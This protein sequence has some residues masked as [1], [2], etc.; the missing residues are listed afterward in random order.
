A[1]VVD[2]QRSAGS[3]GVFVLEQLGLGTVV[4]LVLGGGAIRLLSV[5]HRRNWSDGRYEQLLTFL[6]PIVALAVA[7]VVHGNAFIAAF[8]AGVAFGAGGA[9]PTGQH[10]EGRALHFAEFAEDAAQL[11]AVIAFFLFGNVFVE[12][13]IGQVD[14]RA[15]A[16]A[17]LSLTLVRMGP[18]WVSLLGSPLRTPSRLFVGWFGP[19]GLASIVFG[20]LLLEEADELGPLADELFAV[21]ALT[22]L[23]SVYLHGVTAAP[24]ARRYGAWA[25]RAALASEDQTAHG[26]DDGTGDGTGPS[27]DDAGSTVEHEM[28]PSRWRISRR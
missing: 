17:V 22:V 6:V 13:V 27:A 18:V 16:V 10:G 3:W 8:V 26:T 7:D 9:M 23:G 21:I 15:V 20:L 24:G 2:D 14:A 11:L 12:A 28:P 1:V 25:D 5:T 4:G 19:R